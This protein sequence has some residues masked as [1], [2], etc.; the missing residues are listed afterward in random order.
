MSLQARHP[1]DMKE[2]LIPKKQQNLQLE[3][4]FTPDGFKEQSDKDF[5]ISMPRVFEKIK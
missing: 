3:H 4:D 1:E 5:K 2:N